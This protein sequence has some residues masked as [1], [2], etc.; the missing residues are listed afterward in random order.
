[1]YHCLLSHFVL[2]SSAVSVSTFSTSGAGLL[3]TDALVAFNA[4]FVITLGF[5]SSGK[6]K[7]SAIHLNLNQ[8]KVF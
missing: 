3:S 8:R 7:T 2:A 1:M 4:G 5:V 6:V